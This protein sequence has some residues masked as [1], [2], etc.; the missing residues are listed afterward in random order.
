MVITLLAELPLTPVSTQSA[1]NMLHGPEGSAPCDHLLPFQR[2]ICG[3]PESWPTAHT[4]VAEMA[5]MA[6]SGT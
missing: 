2:S 4:L 5:E 1:S 6:L 3:V